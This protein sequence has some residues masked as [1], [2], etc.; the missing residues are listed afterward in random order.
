MGQKTHPI[1]LRLGVVKTWNS[2]WFAASR[3]YANLLHEDVILGD[4]VRNRLAKASI[5]KVEIERTP[6]RITVTLFTARPGAV[7]GKRGAEVESLQ[8]ELQLLTQKEVHLHVQEVRSPEIDAVLVAESLA[9]QLEQR[10]GFRRAMRKAVTSALRMGA[11]GIRVFCSGRLDGAE[12]ARTEGYREGRVPLHTLRADIDFA[13]ATAHT[14]YGC[15][16]I[17][18]WIS[19]GDILEKQSL[20]KFSAAE[21]LLRGKSAGRPRFGE[22]A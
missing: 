4:Y 16:G 15:I 9:R 7:I 6:K 2:R 14:T 17:K 5:S 11:E 18:V 20:R 10:I 1:G 22:R 12:I 8:K 13:R 21:G 3:D 19:K